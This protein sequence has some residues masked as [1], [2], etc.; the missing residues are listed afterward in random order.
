MQVGDR[1]L[2]LAGRVVAADPG[3]V[4]VAGAGG[5]ARDRDLVVE[6]AAV[7]VVL[8]Q[9]R[10]RVPA[11]PVAAGHGDRGQAER[12]GVD[13]L[14]DEVHAAA[15]VVG[16]PRVGDPTEAH[17][18]ALAGAPP[19]VRQLG[20]AG[21]SVER[22]PRRQAA[23]AAVGP[24]VLLGRADHLARVGRVDRDLRLDLGVVVGRREQVRGAERAAR[25]RRCSADL[26]I[27]TERVGTRRG[28]PSHYSGGRNT[29]HH[30]E[31]KCM[32]AHG[33]TSLDRCSQPP[34][35]RGLTGS[36]R[37]S[38]TVSRMVDRRVFPHR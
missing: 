38:K 7:A 2:A 17:R 37:A 11:G 32:K 25:Q 24:A 18:T 5:I 12:G 4:G 16:H 1:A 8:D 21:P 36:V 23:R 22:V 35:T 34:V 10:R 33:R 28:G 3:R 6:D 13:R 31:R 27:G 19:H 26:Q 29:R 30:G 20:P 9:R 15:L 14:A